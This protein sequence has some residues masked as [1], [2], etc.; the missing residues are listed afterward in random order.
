M[1]N[2][3]LKGIGLLSAVTA[4]SSLLYFTYVP[5]RYDLANTTFEHFIKTVPENAITIDVHA[6]KECEA[7]GPCRAEQI[8]QEIISQVPNMN[9]DLLIVSPGGS[10]KIGKS[11]ISFM[12]QLRSLGVNFVC[13]VQS[14]KSMAFTLLQAC[15]HRIALK[16]ATFLQHHVSYGEIK[17]DSLFMLSREL[18]TF[19][20]HR[21]N[22]NPLE[23]CL[24]TRLRSKDITFT[25]EEA[26]KEGVVDEVL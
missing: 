3:I 10:V 17:S 5:S 11:L 2:K 13:Y 20:A 6:F 18:C 21:M 24:R 19:E 22:K 15:D 1:I 12:I 9:I 7:K 8:V 16:G 23:W 14:A 25:A 4:I 26:L